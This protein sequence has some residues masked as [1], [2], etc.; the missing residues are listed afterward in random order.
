MREYFVNTDFDASL[1]VANEKGDVRVKRIASQETSPMES[2][3]NAYLREMP[4]HF[5]FAAQPDES[6]LLHQPLPPDF[7]TYMQAKGL[8]LPL[9]VRHPAFTPEAEFVPFGWNARAVA[10]ASRY[11][12]PPEVPDLAAVR[13]ANARA[14][15]LDLEREWFPETCRG[16]LIGNVRALTDFLAVRS[17]SEKWVVKGDHGYAGTANRR[18]AGGPLSEDDLRLVEPLFAAHGRVVLEPWDERSCDMAMLFRVTAQG[19]AE[20]F[21]GHGLRNSR[22][23]AF[24]GVEVAPDRMPPA[25]WAHELREHSARL[26]GALSRLGYAG[27]VGVDAYV[28]R[29]PEGLRLRSL[30]DINARLSMAMPAHGL[31]QRLPGRFIRW[32]WHK[33]RKL[34]MPASYDDLETRLGSAAFDP[35]KREGILAVSPLF[36]ED[37]PDAKPKRVGFALVAADAS[38]LESLQSAFDLELGRAP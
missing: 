28:H 29:T 32:S 37:G 14:F 9:T 11:A 36:R 21:R 3:D 16:H 18:L 2:P 33:P 26:A 1:G 22:D 19:T 23:G 25:P 27:P 7:R 8:V 31:A 12:R 4:W 24:L 38:G 35:E 13:T 6:V 15:A 34:R 5:M 10:L 30:V 20:E 17:P